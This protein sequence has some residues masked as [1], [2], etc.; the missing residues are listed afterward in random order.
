M[1]KPEIEGILPEIPNDDRSEV[2]DFKFNCFDWDM[3]N[4]IGPHQFAARAP[5][6]FIRIIEEMF[7]KFQHG[8]WYIEE[9]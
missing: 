6:S 5:R 4:L 9:V 2:A 7:E 8:K 1:P 3:K